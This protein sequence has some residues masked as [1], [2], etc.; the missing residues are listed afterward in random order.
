MSIESVCVCLCVPGS[1][2][3]SPTTLSR[4]IDFG[5]HRDF[6]YYATAGGGGGTDVRHTYNFFYSQ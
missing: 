2:V 5:T 6:E 1:G 3:T 4:F